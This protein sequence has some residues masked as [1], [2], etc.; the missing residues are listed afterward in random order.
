MAAVA[1]ADDEDAFAALEES[2]DDS[3]SAITEDSEDEYIRELHPHDEFRHWDS[4]RNYVPHVSLKTLPRLRAVI[5]INAREH[6]NSYVVSGRLYSLV[7]AISAAHA[8]H[9]M[10]PHLVDVEFAGDHLAVLAFLRDY[11]GAASNID[12]LRAS[13][14]AWTKNRAVLLHLLP[15]L[16]NVEIVTCDVRSSG[17]VLERV[18]EDLSAT[19][20]PCLGVSLRRATVA[21]DAFAR[22]VEACGENVDN[23]CF[24]LAPAF[25]ADDYWR[26]LRP[27]TRAR[28]LI[29]RLDSPSEFGAT[30]M[31]SARARGVVVMTYEDVRVDTREAL[32]VAERFCT[33]TRAVLALIAIPE[34]KRHD[35]DGALLCRVFRFLFNST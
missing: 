28:P 11:P 34:V 14:A 27:S 9:Y 33:A 10:R 19:G 35:G 17:V 6:G 18:C 1:F 22:A 4:N 29:V 21:P 7:S 20:R 3:D 16:R 30:A 15:C 2:D 13:Y 31:R 25:S 32:G 5:S 8:I 23:L 12:T 26:A 24:A